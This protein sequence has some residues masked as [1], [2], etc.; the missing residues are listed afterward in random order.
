MLDTSNIHRQDF[1]VYT[2]NSDG[3]PIEFNRRVSILYN[4]DVIS[5]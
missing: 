4:T 5:C 3:E 2:C 1:D